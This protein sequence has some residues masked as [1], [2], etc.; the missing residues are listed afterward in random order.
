MVDVRRSSQASLSTYSLFS[1]EYTRIPK[2]GLL[3]TSLFWL[4]LKVHVLAQDQQPCVIKLIHLNDDPQPGTRQATTRRSLRSRILRTSDRSKVHNLGSS[5]GLLP[6]A[7]HADIISIA[8]KKTAPSNSVVTPFKSTFFD[9]CPIHNCARD[10]MD[11]TRSCEL[12][13]WA[14]GACPVACALQGYW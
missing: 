9:S 6:K 3:T 14:L 2:T 5:N 11:G 12:Y 1:T 7:G 10:Q 8:S 13:K 4:M